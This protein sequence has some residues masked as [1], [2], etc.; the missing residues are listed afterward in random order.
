MIELMSETLERSHTASMLA[1]A[2]A[3][4]DDLLN[5]PLHL[6]ADTEVLDALRELERL[7][8]RLAAAEHRIVLQIEERGPAYIYSARDTAAVLARALRIDPPE[9]TAR[10]RAA[11]AAGPRRE[12]NGTASP[13]DLPGRSRGTI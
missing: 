7:V 1:D 12:V 4:V 6:D 8:R 2:H 9:A 13:G 10:F 3:L 5:A 11:E